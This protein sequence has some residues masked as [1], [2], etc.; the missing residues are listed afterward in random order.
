MDNP[1]K[2]IILA[3]N[4]QIGLITQVK[5]ELFYHKRKKW[6]ILIP[7]W[8]CGQSSVLSTVFKVTPLFGF[9]ADGIFCL[10]SR[11]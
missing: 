10:V 6:K 9:G 4:F 3:A 11:K 2:C 5:S 7:S 1:H 8:G